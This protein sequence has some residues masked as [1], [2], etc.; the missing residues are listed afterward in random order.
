M[1]YSHSNAPDM[2]YMM[3]SYLD[4]ADNLSVTVIGYD[5]AGFGQSTG[6]PCD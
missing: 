2:G 3:D 1:I 6:A 5:Y 4:M